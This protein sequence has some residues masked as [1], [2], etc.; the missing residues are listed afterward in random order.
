MR[1]GGTFNLNTYKIIKA[2][3]N[4]NIITKEDNTIRMEENESI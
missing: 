2:K 3:N 4:N 1:H